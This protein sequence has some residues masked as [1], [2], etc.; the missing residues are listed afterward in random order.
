MSIAAVDARFE[1]GRVI[2]RILPVYGRNFIGFTLLSATTITPLIVRYF[3]PSI[4]GDVFHGRIIFELLSLLPALFVQSALI[5][6]AEIDFTGRKE[7]F[8]GYISAGFRFFLPALG[9][10]IASFIATAVGLIVLIVPGVICFAAISVSV[11]VCI[12]EHTGIIASMERSWMLTYGYR[13]QIFGLLA[14]YFVFILVFAFALRPLS[15]L[16]AMSSQAVKFSS[17]PFVIGISVQTFLDTIISSI[18]SASIYYELRMIK[19]SG[20]SDA[21]A[22]AFD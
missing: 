13:W 7:V 11:P 1:M 19:E 22:A 18:G 15:G 8:S 12:A 16:A 3:I 6:A 17:L 4:I 20:G 10:T 14:I 21:L 5:Y 2:G 9:I